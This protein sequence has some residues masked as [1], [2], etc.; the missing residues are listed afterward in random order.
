MRLEDDHLPAFLFG[1]G[2]RCGVDRQRVQMAL[3]PFWLTALAKQ[4]TFTQRAVL[5]R[6]CRAA[7]ESDSCALS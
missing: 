4:W 3:P 1:S 5:S 2:L 6:P 7:Y